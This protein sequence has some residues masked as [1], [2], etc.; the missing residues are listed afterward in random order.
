MMNDDP[1]SVLPR[2]T[3]NSW[4]TSTASWTPKAA[5]ASRPCW[6]PTRKSAAACNRWSGRGTCLDQL[7]T[8]PVGEPFTHTTLEMVAVAARDDVEHDRAEAP[9]RRRRRRLAIGGGLL[10]A[11]AAGF[12][13]V[14][15]LAPDPNRQL[16]EDLPVLLNFDEYRQVE[17]I[18][19][20]RLLRKEG[21][22]PG[23]GGGRIHAAPPG[24]D[25]SLAERRQLVEGMSPDKKEQLRRAEERFLA[26]TPPSSNACGNW[27]RKLQEDPDAAQAPSDHAPLLRLVE[28]LPLYSRRRIG[29]TAGPTSGSSGSSGCGKNRPAKAAGGWTA[30]TPRSCGNG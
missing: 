5:V 20:L 6:R 25:E 8:A 1:S 15:S 4:R 22:F 18:E 21:L 9:R 30:R 16:L 14:A 12:L 29:R 10:A 17:N 23:G 2:W 26:W 3:S 28:D 13:A 27:T 24:A 11:A 19:F 7:D